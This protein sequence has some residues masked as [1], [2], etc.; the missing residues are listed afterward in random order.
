[1][2]F[3]SSI[4]LLLSLWDE[5]ELNS[6]R[7]GTIIKAQDELIKLLLFFF[8][9]WPKKMWFNKRMVHEER[10]TQTQQKKIKYMNLWLQIVTNVPDSLQ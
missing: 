1:M 5:G 3:P 4:S 9:F 2:V 6:P 8:S 10:R 7:I